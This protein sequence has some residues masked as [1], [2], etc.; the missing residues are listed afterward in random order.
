MRAKTVVKLMGN[1][2]I[3]FVVRCL[4]SNLGDSCQAS[5]SIRATL[6]YLTALRWF[7]AEPDARR[8][9]FRCIIGDWL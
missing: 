5:D 3:D 8:H 9:R 6:F 4:G 2:A 7:K 1:P